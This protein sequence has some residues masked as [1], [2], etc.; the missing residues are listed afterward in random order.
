MIQAILIVLPS[1]FN[2]FGELEVIS[3]NGSRESA[4]KFDFVSLSLKI[5][6]NENKDD[7][8]GALIAE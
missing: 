7:Y 3:F 5:K 6:V 4:P 2:F 8:R 1:S